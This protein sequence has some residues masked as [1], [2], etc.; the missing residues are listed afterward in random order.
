MHKKAGGRFNDKCRWGS[1]CGKWD[2][3]YFCITQD[4]V[5]YS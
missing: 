1:F 2:K 4:G 5:I 3:R